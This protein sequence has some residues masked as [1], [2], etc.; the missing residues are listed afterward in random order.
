MI[1]EPPVS[2]EAE[3]S[4]LTRTLSTVLEPALYWLDNVGN[5]VSLTGRTLIWLFRPPFRPAQR[6][7][8]RRRHAF[9]SPVFR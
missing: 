7:R 4:P 1:Q 2:E 3:K 6:W 9:R 8:A 5:I